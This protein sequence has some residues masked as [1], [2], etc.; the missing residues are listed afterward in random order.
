M[1]KFEKI[2]ERYNTMIIN[3]VITYQLEIILFL[4]Q[5]SYLRTLK[6]HIMGWNMPFSLITNDIFTFECRKF[7]KCLP[8]HAHAKI[9]RTPKRS[10][11][12]KPPSNTGDTVSAATWRHQLNTL[13]QVALTPRVKW[14]TMATERR[15]S[16]DS[17]VDLDSQI[18][19]LVGIAPFLSLVSRTPLL[20]SIEVIGSHEMCAANDASRGGVGPMCP[21]LPN[22]TFP[23]LPICSI[24][25]NEVHRTAGRVGIV[26][27]SH[28]TLFHHFYSYLIVSVI[29]TEKINNNASSTR[30][31]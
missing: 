8:S 31:A 26:A 9:K 23:F 10:I 11:S 15:S 12:R 6:G 20:I 4:F 16:S 17:D 3:Y 28:N 13:P 24:S 2:K 30:L 5:F 29:I 18:D 22:K 21:T 7:H 25:R 19:I 27:V 14:L 1:R